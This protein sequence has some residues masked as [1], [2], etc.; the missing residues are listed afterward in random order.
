MRIRGLVSV[1]QR[2]AAAAKV[3]ALSNSLEEACDS[4]RAGN[5]VVRHR[6]GVTEAPTPALMGP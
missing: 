4:S 5:V 3:G 1:G 6:S 2:P